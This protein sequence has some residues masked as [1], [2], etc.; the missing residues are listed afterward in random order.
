[1]GEVSQH[2]EYFAFGETFIEE[3]KDSHNSPYKFNGK[4]LDEES[5]YTYFGARYYDPRIRIWASTDPL[6]E[7]FPSHSLYSFCF[8]N[9]LRFVDP[10]RRNP[11]DIIVY[12]SNN[13]SFTIKTNL[14]KSTISLSD[15][16]LS[17]DFKGGYLKR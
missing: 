13:S 10:D 16:G 8:N 12:G 1:V 6:A 11:F 2:S 5:G 14:V 7:K 4:E 9:P 17:H 3:H 15:Y